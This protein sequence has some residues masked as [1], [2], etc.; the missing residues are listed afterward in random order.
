MG[1]SLGLHHPDRAV[2]LLQLSGGIQDLLSTNPQGF[3]RHFPQWGTFELA[4][5]MEWSARR[6][7]DRI[8]ALYP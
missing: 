8:S 4:S 6:E 3:Y 5:H 7:S 2:A 1:L